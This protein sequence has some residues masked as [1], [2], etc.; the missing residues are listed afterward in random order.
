MKSVSPTGLPQLHMD[1]VDPRLREAAE[2]MEANFMKQMVRAMRGTVD[3]SAETKDNQSIQLFRGML[4]DHYAEMATHQQNG[5]GI[6]EMIVR[7]LTQQNS[8]P[9]ESGA[10]NF[11]DENASVG[12]AAASVNS[13]ES[14]GK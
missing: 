7:Y 12:N 3:E 11:P 1:R 2:G 10:K 6:A 13:D 14:G 8:V 5:I 9:L 4:D